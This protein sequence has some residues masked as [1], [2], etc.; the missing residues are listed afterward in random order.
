[1][2]V[3]I[4]KTEKEP[5]SRSLIFIDTAIFGNGKRALVAVVDRKVVYKRI[6]DNCVEIDHNIYDFMDMLDCFYAPL[7]VFY[8]HELRYL[9]GFIK[10]MNENKKYCFIRESH[11]RPSFKIT[12]KVL[13]IEI[14]AALEYEK[15]YAGKTVLI[16]EF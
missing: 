15:L 13:A 6:Y 8:S 10:F 11:A 1:M 2:P 9:P 4:I 16:N 7:H 14:Q 5:I 12:E 3:N